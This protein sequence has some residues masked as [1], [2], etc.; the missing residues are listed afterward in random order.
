[1]GMFDYLHFEGKA[2]QTKDTPSQ[3]LDDYEIRGDQLWYRDVEHEWIEDEDAFFG[4]YLKEVSYKW[5]FEESFD[6]VIDFYD[7]DLKEN[8]WVEYHTLFNNGIM[9]KFEKVKDGPIKND[10]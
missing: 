9:I 8:H 3:C 10:E 1:M 6:G 7:Y 2:Y 4:G 5:V